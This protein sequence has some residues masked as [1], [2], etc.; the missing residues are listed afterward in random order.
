MENQQKEFGDDS[1]ER[2]RP[3]GMN[4]GGR[5]NAFEIVILYNGLERTLK[6]NSHEAIHAV[7][8]RSLAL[9]GVQGD[10][11]LALFLDG[12]APLNPNSN[13]GASGVVPGSRVLL[14]PTQVQSGVTCG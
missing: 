8:A 5:D 3:D 1:G 14:R 12:N 4:G 2:G 13:V 9:Y 10:Q 6:V 7:L 11:T